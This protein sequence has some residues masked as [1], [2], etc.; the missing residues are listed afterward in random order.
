MCVPFGTMTSSGASEIPAAALPPT[1]WALLDDRPGN[2]SQTRAVVEALGWP[3]VEKRLAFRPSARLHNRILDASLFGLRGESTATLTPPWPDLVVAAGR[4]S[5]PVVRYIGRASGGASRLVVLGRKAGDHADAFDLVA[6]PAYAR[7]FEHPKRFVT[8]VP[9][10]G[11]TPAALARAADAWRERFHAFA[12]PIVGVLVGGAT[13]QFSLSPDTARRLGEDVVRVAAD[14]GGS[15]IATTSRRTAPTAALAFASALRDVDLAHR[16]LPGTRADENPYRGLLALADE[17]IVTAD[18][19]SMLA[20]ATASGRP[21]FVYPLPQRRSFSA[22]RLPREFIAA[23]ATPGGTGAGAL[24]AR[25]IELGWSRP[26]RDL[27]LMHEHLIER[28]HAGRF[29][30]P[31]NRATSTPASELD[32]FVARVR[33]LFDSTEREP[34]RN[35]PSL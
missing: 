33:G 4:R 2:T 34:R 13:G 14:C 18:S 9:F 17:L 30:T 35:G 10:H 6:T 23:R 21:V 27:A 7:L 5:A 29:R 31:Y 22:L 16:W 1:V 15:V 25:L 20:E 32:A 28:G 24:F 19:E 8:S 3:S 12:R 11:V 26:T